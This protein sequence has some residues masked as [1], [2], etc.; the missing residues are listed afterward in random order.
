[1]YLALYHACPH[2][3]AAHVTHLGIIQDASLIIHTQVN[4]INIKIYH[5]HISDPLENSETTCISWRCS[6]EKPLK[7]T[8][9]C[10]SPDIA[11]R[12]GILKDPD[13]SVE[14]NPIWNKLPMSL[15]IWRKLR[16]K[17][18][19]IK[20]TFMFQKACYL[21][22]LQYLLHHPVMSRLHALLRH[23]PLL[24]AIGDINFFCLHDIF[25]F[26]VY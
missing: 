18:T 2:K 13:H 24:C 8:L 21:K 16:E 22:H 4:V 23:L 6:Q 1:M 14:R 5:Y 12:M 10:E 19:E 15:W 17:L 26:P 7:E 9:G 25:L 20:K 3:L 11:L